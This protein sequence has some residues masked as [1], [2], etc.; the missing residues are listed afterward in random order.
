VSVIGTGGANKVE[1]FGSCAFGAN[2]AFEY[3]TVKGGGHTCCGLDAVTGPGCAS[4]TNPTNG[5]FSAETIWDFFSTRR[6]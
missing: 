4:A 2:A 3:V 6:W 1:D 5:M